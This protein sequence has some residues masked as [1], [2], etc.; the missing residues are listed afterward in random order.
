[1]TRE[2]D[3]YN[4]ALM[5]HEAISDALQPY[6]EFYFMDDK[7]HQQIAP[8]ALFRDLDPLDPVSN[9]Y[10]INCNNPLLSSQERTI[11]CTPAQIAAATAAPNAGCT[12][13]GS[14]VSNNGT[15]VEIGRRN[16]EGGGRFSDYEHENDRAVLGTKGNF[17][18]AWSY[19][20]Y[21]QYYYTTFFNSND[22][23]LNFQSIGELD[24]KFQAAVK[25][26]D[27][28]T[29]AEILH[30]DM[31]L[32][33]GD[34]R[35]FT[36]EE[37]LRESEQKLLAYEVQDEEPGTQTVR[38]YGDTGV[39]TALLRIKG[40]NKGVGFDRRVWFSDT[41][42]RTPSGWKYFIGQASLALPSAAR[43]PEPSQLPST[44]S[45]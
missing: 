2:D 6:S 37:Q 25:E 24:R 8:A 15:N 32:V 13:T 36:R 41:Y 21:G 9:N 3:R 30:P 28:V 14:T 17:L 38:V 33:L 45:K 43:D 20:V 23:Y 12:F 16:I 19:D 27:A 26:N 22:K 35:T 11:L 42:V 7:T 4:A 29:M 1:M 10:S 5:T 44:H 18:D 34:G 31:I 39:V 40:T